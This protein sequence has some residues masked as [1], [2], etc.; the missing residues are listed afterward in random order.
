MNR[1]FGDNDNAIGVKIG[2]FPS[3]FALEY[4]QN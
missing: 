3:C 2:A 4:T 1:T